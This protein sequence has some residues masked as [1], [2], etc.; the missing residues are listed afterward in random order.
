RDCHALRLLR[1]NEH[2]YS[3]VVSLQIAMGHLHYLGDAYFRKPI[4]LDEE[5]P[6]IAACGIFRECESHLL[7][8]EDDLFKR[9]DIFALSP[10][11]FFRRNRSRPKSLQDPQQRVADL[12]DR[13]LG[14]D[15]RTDLENTRIVTGK[16]RAAHRS[17]LSR[18]DQRLIET[19][20][21][22]C[23]QDVRQY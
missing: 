10:L 14:L 17:G 20:A 2:S 13:L 18:R 8:V 22:R 9:I 21:R 7:A 6:P 16:G 3:P 1:G 23:S 11:Q 4:T 19:P 5:E 12:F 15:G